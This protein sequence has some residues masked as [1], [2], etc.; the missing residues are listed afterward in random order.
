[1]PP[2]PWAPVALA[3]WRYVALPVLSP[4][5]LGT[6]IILVCQCRRAYALQFAR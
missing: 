4:A 3:Y 6:F 2:K 5:L 1:M